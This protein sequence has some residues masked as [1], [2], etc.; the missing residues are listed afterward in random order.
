MS[1]LKLTIPT[2]FTNPNL[3]YLRDDPVLPNTGAMMLID[4]THP[5]SAWAAGV[6]ADQ[7]L[8]PNLASSQ[9]QALLGSSAA[10]DLQ[11]RLHKPATF[12]GA[13][14]LI[15]RTT[16]GGLHGISPQSGASITGSGPVLALSTKLI[17]Y[18]LENPKH[19]YFM[20]LWTR[21]T[22][23]PVS[24]FNNSTIF[25]LNGSGQQTNSYLFNVA[26]A[27]SA[28]L[29]NGVYPLNI[30]PNVTS[31]R[32]GLRDTSTTLRGD[33]FISMATDTWRTATAGLEDSLPGDGTNTTVT[34][35]HAGG[36]IA[37]GSAL[38][39]PG[40]GATGNVANGNFAVT[41]NVAHKNNVSS[42]IVYR[43][44][45]EDLTVSGRS[46]ATVDALSWAEYQKQVLTPGGRY[47][48]DTFTDPATLP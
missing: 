13:A 9:L 28:N 19:D 23:E 8:L 17:K 14:G 21:V 5:A 12:S 38:S 6:P 47:Y 10:A 3:K 37:F 36:G 32:L 41:N 43:L 4:P 42:H 26:A 15:E 34:G 25:A 2:T 1:G 30:R 33:R 31:I 44:Y 20:S 45:L 11:P 18:I 48:G 16:K 46:Y 22:R 40:I 29:A 7:A 24:P 35:S 39:W 27:Q